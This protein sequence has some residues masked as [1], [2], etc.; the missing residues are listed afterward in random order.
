VG[1]RQISTPEYVKELDG[2][3]RWLLD[4]LEISRLPATGQIIEID[5]TR[6]A[7]SIHPL[8]AKEHRVTFANLILRAAALASLTRE[9]AIAVCTDS[10]SDSTRALRCD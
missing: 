1:G 2:A 10:A 4:G 9:P 3:G 5:V 7:E 8:R 6:A